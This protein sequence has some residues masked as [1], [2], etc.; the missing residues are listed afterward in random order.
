MRVTETL[1]KNKRKI[2][3]DFIV[4]PRTRP[5]TKVCDTQDLTLVSYARKYEK[6]NKIVL[7]VS[8][9]MR[10]E[11]K[12]DEKPN[13]VRHYN[14]TKGGTGNFDKFCHSCTV[15][16]KTCRWPAKYFCGIL[17]QTIVNARIFVKFKL[18]N[19]G[20]DAKVMAIDCLENLYAHLVTSYLEQGYAVGTLRKNVRLGMAGIKKKDIGAERALVRI[21]VPS[22]MRCVL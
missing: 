14:T 18:K 4:A 1:K 9:F 5:N 6:S 19:D 11:E 12:T 16:G 8:G 7:V 3:A 10:T 20:N 15:A 21:N 17:D 13:I 22:A 2:L